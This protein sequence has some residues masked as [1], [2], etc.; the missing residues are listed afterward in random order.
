MKVV[1]HMK[2]LSRMKNRE[3]DIS[4]SVRALRRED[5]K[6]IYKLM[7]RCP[8]EEKYRLAAEHVGI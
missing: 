6:D 3:G 7:M 8:T 5:L 2:S 4:E 1:I